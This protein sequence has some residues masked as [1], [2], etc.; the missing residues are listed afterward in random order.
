MCFGQFE[1]SQVKVIIII[2]MCLL[3]FN[4]EREEKL[5]KKDFNFKM[6]DD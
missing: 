2:S 6:M 3:F 5:L 4:L 1:I